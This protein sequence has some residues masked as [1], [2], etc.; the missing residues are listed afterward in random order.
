MATKKI[1]TIGIIILFLVLTLGIFLILSL[2]KVEMVKHG[3]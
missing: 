1:G 3:F 2:N